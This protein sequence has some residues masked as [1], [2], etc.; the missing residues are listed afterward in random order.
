V[1]ICTPCRKAADGKTPRR[2]HC[3]VC[4]RQIEVMRTDVPEAE[5]RLYVHGAHG[6]R[7]DGSKGPPVYRNV[8]HCNGLCP[9]QHR[10][11]GAWRGGPAN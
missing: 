10:E 2:P 1:S 4:T 9:C 6:E 8:G 5:Q 7:C 3:P 11:K